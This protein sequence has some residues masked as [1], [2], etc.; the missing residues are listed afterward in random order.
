MTKFILTLS[1]AALALSGCQKK[2]ELSPAD[3]AEVAKLT[4]AKDPIG[5]EI[6]A[7]RQQIRQ[8]YNNRRFAELETRATELRHSKETF[9]NGSWKIAQFYDSF[10][11][12]DE[13]PEAMW[14]LHEKIHQEWIEQFPQSITARV[15]SA[16]FFENYAWHARGRG[17][18]DK[19]KD[20]DWQLF[21]QRLASAQTALEEA[22]RLPEK[23][24]VSYRVT[25]RLALGQGWTK[26]QFDQILE[27]AKKFEPKFWGYDIIRAQS[28]LPRWYG[29]PGDWE[30]YADQAAARPDGLG[31]EIY[32]RIVIYIESY[33]GNIFRESKVSWP[34][35]REGLAVLRKKY[36]RSPSLIQ[37]TAKLAG[38]AGDRPLAREM[39]DKIGAGYLPEVWGKPER[40]V[41]DRKWV[42]SDAP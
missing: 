40:F 3:K 25:L 35:V 34:K 6:F 36:P 13:E 14:Q 15:A 21:A 5:E 24:P 41:R 29:E 23:D 26:Y 8:D 22:N 30:A 17:Y 19:V 39:F 33:H 38:M 2:T 37:E 16:S 10:D 18:A 20:N 28:L 7:F 4:P 31:I 12:R 32:A 11:C 42:Y 1:I 9:D 27:E